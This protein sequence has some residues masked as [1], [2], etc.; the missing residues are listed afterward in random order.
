[1]R[2]RRIL[3]VDDE[4]FI[5]S[6]LA[7]K[8]GE[9]GDDVRTASDG[10]EG[11]AAA[12]EWLPDLIVSDYQMPTMSGFEMALRLK[13]NPSTARIPVMILTARGHRLRPSELASTSVQLLFPKPFSARELLAKANELVPP[14]SIDAQGVR[15]KLAS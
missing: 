9:Q 2:Q 10:G 6:V 13:Q 4:S 7:L 8:F 5:V 14:S 1:M 3:I 11:Y 15:E 12:V